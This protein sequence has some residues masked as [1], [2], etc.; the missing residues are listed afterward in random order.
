MHYSSTPFQGGSKMMITRVTA[1]NYCSLSPHV[2]YKIWQVPAIIH[3]PTLRR[4]HFPRTK[5]QHSLSICFFYTSWRR[6]A[7]SSSPFICMS[8]ELVWQLENHRH[9]STS[10]LPESFCLLPLGN[11]DLEMT[12]LEARGHVMRS[13]AILSGWASADNSVHLSDGRR[14]LS[15]MYD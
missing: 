14:K 9:I 10:N 11:L 5:D 1:N 6:R 2:G 15:W 8:P 4:L 3:C 7:N 12:L 13:Q